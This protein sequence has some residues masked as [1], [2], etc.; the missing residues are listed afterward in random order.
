[1]DLSENY[2][3]NFQKLLKFLRK[4]PHSGYMFAMAD[5]YRFISQINS[6]LVQEL[7]NK[8]IDAGIVFLQSGSADT[9]VSQILTGARQ[10]QSVIVP[11][12]FEVI[13]NTTSGLNDLLQLN[14]SREELRQLQTP[15]LFWVDAAS[16]NTIANHAPD[17]FSQRRFTTI[18]F[19]GKI[20]NPVQEVLEKP[21]W[22]EFISSDKFKAI[23]ARI[24]TLKR[25]LTDAEESGYHPERIADE[26]A[27]PL[28]KEYADLNLKDKAL[29]ILEKYLPYS[30][31]NDPV[32]LRQ[33]A[34]VYYALHQHD[35]AIETM[36]KANV[37][38]Q[39]DVPT[40]GVAGTVPGDWFVNQLDIADW[41]HDTGRTTD[42]LNLLENTVEVFRQNI[43]FF[44]YEWGQDVLSLFLERIGTIQLQLQHIESAISYYQECIEIRSQLLAKNP[45]NERFQMLLSGAY[46]FL[47]DCYEQG[48]D[49]RQ[50]KFYF[51]E[52]L[53]ILQNMLQQ[54]LSNEALQREIFVCYNRL[55]GLSVTM[56]NFAQ[57]KINYEKSLSIIQQLVN[58]SPYSIGFRRDLAVQYFKLGE[59]EEKQTNA[60]AANQYFKLSYSLFK[61]LVATNPFSQVL[62]TDKREA[63]EKL[64]LSTP[65]A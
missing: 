27:L 48:G 42:A 46:T 43:S 14:F 8:N 11:N 47:A 62:Q 21:E 58:N 32:H 7:L 50:A 10:Y 23:E 25:R 53:G 33:L 39:K 2:Q 51:E 65:K 59:L 5:D 38:L 4:T 13:N 64:A 19:T 35:Q 12:L 6:L 63:E 9:L 37:L 26:I 18:H 20:E 3:F 60:N 15:V 31:E 34:K 22:K 41:L 45:G 55:A 54:Q 24:E 56:G 52:S 29:S 40:S 49:L 30:S 57:A 28:A 36:Q 44:A 1:M 17:L 16:L 61:E